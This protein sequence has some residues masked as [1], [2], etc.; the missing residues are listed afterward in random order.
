[1]S[2]KSNAAVEGGCLCGAVRYR[3]SGPFHDRTICHCETCRRASGAP[4]VAWF[5]VPTGR[6]RWLGGTARSYQ[7][8]QRA[9]RTFCPDCGT[10]LTYQRVDRP[11]EIDVTIA[12]LDQPATCLPEDHVWTAR[13]LPWIKLDDGLPVYPQDRNDS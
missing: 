13:Q 2:D 9:T 3:A 10:A 5:S 4:L 1:M 7:S 12:S 6:F 11:E 8:S